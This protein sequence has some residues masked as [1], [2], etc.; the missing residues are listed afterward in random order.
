MVRRRSGKKPG[1]E[2]IDSKFCV[3]VKTAASHCC[4]L[5]YPSKR[6]TICLFLC[7]RGSSGRFVFQ[8]C[9]SASCMLQASPA[10]KLD[11]TNANNAWFSFNL[12][13]E[14]HFRL[15]RKVIATNG[16]L[17][18]SGCEFRPQCVLGEQVLFAFVHRKSGWNNGQKPFW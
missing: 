11:C 10:T 15:E 16:G 7:A 9:G 1:V 18:P 3:R 13:Q 17:S 5:Q 12:A 14:F 4:F 8:N 6:R 2:N